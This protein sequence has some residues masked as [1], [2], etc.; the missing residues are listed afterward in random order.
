MTLLKQSNSW[1][2]NQ[3]DIMINESLEAYPKINDWISFTDD[4]V[5]DVRAGKVEIGQRITS[6]FC[7]IVSSELEVDIS[8]V[9][10]LCGDTRLTPNEGYTAASCSMEITGS[11]LRYVA[12]FAV[13]PCLRVLARRGWGLSG[14]GTA[15]VARSLDA[16]IAT[17]LLV[18]D[19]ANP[20]C[21][22]RR[23]DNG[24]P[25]PH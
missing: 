24:V 8:R 6:A 4:G 21:V 17:E 2:G 14:T 13:S 7:K 19:G 22:Q 10:L 9:H 5:V 12:A 16:P 1:F 15:P 23:G 11:A 25:D 3:T 20:A 18:P